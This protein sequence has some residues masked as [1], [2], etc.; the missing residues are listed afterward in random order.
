M[1]KSKKENLF[2]RDVVVTDLRVYEL[3]DNV[4]YFYY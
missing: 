3:H 4:F 1:D 2:A